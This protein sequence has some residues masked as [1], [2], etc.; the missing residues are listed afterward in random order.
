[1]TDQSS[2]A[3]GGAQNVPTVKWD[4]S[5]MNSS[6]ANVAN[7]TS[8]REE[9]VL[10]FGM[11]KNWQAGKDEV[12]V[13]LTQRLIMSPFAAARLHALLGGVLEQYESR[14][15]KLPVPGKPE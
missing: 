3:A 14:F 11:N 12:T 7:V 5:S 1:M 8:T 15:G 4:D 2:A 9:V 10:F 13:E 6:Y